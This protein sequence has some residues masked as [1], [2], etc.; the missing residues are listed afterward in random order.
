MPE[1]S[2]RVLSEFYAFGIPER[3][4]RTERHKY[5]HSEGD[6][7]QLYDLEND[8]QENDNRIDDPVCAEICENLD[9][10]LCH[11]WNIPDT[12]DI[13]KHRGDSRPGQKSCVG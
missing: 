12:S 1:S 13:P 8:P 7:H 4:I 3:M 10:R 5:V 11:E 6:L 9:P 2:V